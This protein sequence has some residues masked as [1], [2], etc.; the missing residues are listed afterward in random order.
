MRRAARVVPARCPPEVPEG[1]E[2]DGVVVAVRAAQR[3][4]ELPHEDVAH[5]AVLHAQ[6]AAPRLGR[7]RRVAATDPSLR[8]TRLYTALYG[9]TRLHSR[10][11]GS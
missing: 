1:V 9:S 10:R 7:L 6:V 5:A 2:G 3:A 11:T 8:C 4:L